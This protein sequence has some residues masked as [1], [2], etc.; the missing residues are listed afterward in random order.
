MQFGCSIAKP[1]IRAILIGAVVITLLSLTFG[2]RP[3]FAASDLDSSTLWPSGGGAA[4]SVA[5]GSQQ[6]S[7]EDQSSGQATGACAGVTIGLQ[8]GHWRAAEAP[9]PLNT[10]SGASGGGK[11]EAEVNLANAQAAAD[12]LR[13]A[14]CK[15]DILPTVIPEGYQ[16]TLVVAIHANGGPSSVR[17]FFVDHSP[18]RA[19]S[20]EDQRLA[21]AITSAYQAVGIPYTDGSTP[22]SRYYYGYRAVSSE[23]PMVLIETGFLTN[24][25]DQRILIGDPKLVGGSI[26]KGILDYLASSAANGRIA[27]S[28]IAGGQGTAPPIGNGRG[29]SAK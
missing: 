10:S 8:A 16:A 27:A 28:S 13:S 18:R 3:T 20:V 1:S 29:I 21:S 25:I 12:V 9:P 4:S 14:G 7:V 19:T 15:V 6:G 23:T 11:T 17:G 22:D 26:A 2:A 5:A 24:P